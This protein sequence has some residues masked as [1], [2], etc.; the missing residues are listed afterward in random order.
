MEN[1]IKKYLFDILECIRIIDEFTGEK[2]IFQAFSDSL[3]MQDAVIRR[4][5]II[6]EAT[7]Q[8]MSLKPDIRISFTRKIIGLRNR[9]VHDY[10]NIALDNIWAIVINSL[11]NLKIEIETLLN[12]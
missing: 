9:I 8:L 10:A 6:G 7:N 5:E 4:L 1:E 3:M 2:K 12:E 11:P